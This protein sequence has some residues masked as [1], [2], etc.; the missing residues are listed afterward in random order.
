MNDIKKMTDWKELE[1][2]L[3]EKENEFDRPL[4][5][6]E[7]LQGLKEK[8]KGQDH[9]LNDVAKI[10]RINM[11]KKSRSKP[12]A[13]FL[14]LGPTG[15]GKTE[16]AKTLANVLH[17]SEDS[18][19]RFDC[20][21]L[22]SA[23]MGK[24]RLVGSALGYVGSEMGGQLTRPMFSNKK[25]IILFDEIEKAHPSIF[26]LFLQLMGE[27]RLTEQGSG[28]VADFT[29]SIVIMTS[30]AHAE[31]IVSIRES[32]KDEYEELNAIKGFLADTKSFRPELMGR[33]DKV[34]IFN[35]LEGMII[36]EIALLKI[37]K[38]ARD[39]GVDVKFVDPSSLVKILLEN[40]KVSRFGIRELER[41]I[42][43]EYAEMIINAREEGAKVIEIKEGDNQN[44]VVNKAA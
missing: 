33:I 8:V 28:K 40:K 31:K 4:N 44:I 43:D 15:T 5:E 19:V 39:Y 36:A 6:E 25:R 34:A 13:N 1:R 7:I 27:G 37:A 29:H 11:A 24:T 30:N 3:Q 26:D 17:G 22:S 10:I 21:E 16:L 12:V 32:V 20:S 23:D 18:I 42:A 41:I 38:L 14:F 9:V 35:P 2:R